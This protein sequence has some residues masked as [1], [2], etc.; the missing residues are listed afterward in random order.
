MHLSSFR[1][2]L[3]AIGLLLLCIQT[4]QAAI[5][6]EAI[7]GIASEKLTIEVVASHHEPG[8]DLTRVHL[9]ARV[10]AVVHSAT[11]LEAG[12]LILIVY[13]QNHVAY[14]KQREQRK[15]Q[16]AKGGWTG[17]QLMFAPPV[18]EAGEYHRAHLELR[19]DGYSS[20]KVYTPVANQYSFEEVS[21]QEKIKQSLDQKD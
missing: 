16:L 19:E 8:D 1:S 21:L 2:S 5:D 11:G 3:L 15:K 9:S 17:P 18:L 13:Y 4:A 6:P 12:D 7:R 20:G 14:R 10:V